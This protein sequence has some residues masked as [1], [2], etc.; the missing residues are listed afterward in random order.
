M[1]GNKSSIVKSQFQG[2]TVFEG[3]H[4]FELGY[5]VFDEN[6]VLLMGRVL[7]RCPNLKKLQVVGM[8]NMNCRYTHDFM[9]SFVVLVRKF[10]KVDFQ[11]QKVIY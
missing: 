9:A 8:M 3:V 2:S 5:P 1:V 11:F 7:K 6:L 10:S 4:F